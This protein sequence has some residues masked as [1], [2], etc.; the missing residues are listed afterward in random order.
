MSKALDA[1]MKSKQAYVL[2]K[3]SLEARLRSRMDDELLNIRTQIDISIRYA[4][5]LGESKADIL[6]AMGTKDYHTVNISLERT[7]GVAQV[8]GLDPL[9]SVYSLSGEYVT[10]NYINH[11][12]KSYTGK[13]S[14]T[15]KI[16]DDGSYLFFAEDALWSDD[17]KTRNDVVAVLDGRNDGPYFEELSAW[18]AG[19]G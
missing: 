12:E 5:D 19:T 6:R 16:L 15:Y 7:R 17:Y 9:D 11:G 14:F 1:V 4:F 10:A 13:A 2:A 8:V 3:S 18:M